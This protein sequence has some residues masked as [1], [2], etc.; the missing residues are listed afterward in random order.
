MRE[1][2]Y[3]THYSDGKKAVKCLSLGHKLAVI[4]IWIERISVGAFS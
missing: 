1:K 4:K 3:L 2:S